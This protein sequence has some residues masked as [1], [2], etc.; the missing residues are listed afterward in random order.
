MQRGVALAVAGDLPGAAAVFDP[1]VMCNLCTL[2]CPEH[3][4]PNH[5][6]L[7]ARRV[8]TALSLRPVDLIARLAGIESPDG[9]PSKEQ[10][11]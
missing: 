6:G 5:L 1:C 11:R 2:A 3:I 9:S 10:G 7:A 4:W 8:H